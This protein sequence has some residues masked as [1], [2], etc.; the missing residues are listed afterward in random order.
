MP[1][2]PEY[3]ETEA[4]QLSTARSTAQIDKQSLDTRLLED[5]E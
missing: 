4:L 2:W 1:V 3:I 5:I